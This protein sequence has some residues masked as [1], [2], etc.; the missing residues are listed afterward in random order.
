MASALH[1]PLR[2]LP[3]AV[4]GLSLTEHLVLQILC[5]GGIFTLNRVWELLQTERE[6]LPWIG[7]L[8]LLHVVEQMH[9]ASEPVFI[10]IAAASGQTFPQQLSI[11]GV[12]RAMGTHCALHR[13]G[14]VEYRF[15]PES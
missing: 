5:E 1:R 8:G 11:T 2:E 12:G 7:D 10:R 3:L 9:K 15:S 4:N 14:W 6:P 13:D